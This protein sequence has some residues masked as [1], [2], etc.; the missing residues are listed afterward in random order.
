MMTA[1]QKL[2]LLLLCVVGIQTESLA[3]VQSATSPKMECKREHRVIAPKTPSRTADG[4][5]APNQALLQAKFEITND[6][7]VRVIEYPKSGDELDTYNST[8]I[9]QRGR[10]QTRYDI[11]KL[12]KG[13]TVLRL[14]EIVSLCTAS[15]E[16]QIILAFE[17]GSTGAVEGFAIL[18]FTPGVVEVKAL[19][20]ANQGRIVVKDATARNVELWSASP[21]DAGLCTACKKKYTV[22]E[23]TVGQQDVDC[24]RARTVGRF[25]PDAFLKHR[26]EISPELLHGSGTIP[27]Q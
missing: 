16:G 15:D 6:T 26:I 17:G 27:K 9:V 25:A 14:V 20:I 13:G 12:I 21:G 7:S 8:V 2:L 5:I 10:A 19:P 1:L 23:C 18:R 22:R 4:S 3:F 24:A 11:G